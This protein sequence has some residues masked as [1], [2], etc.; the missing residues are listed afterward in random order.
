[1]KADEYRY[2]Q[3]H[4]RTNRTSIWQTTTAFLGKYQH[5]KK[6]NKRRRKVGRDEKLRKE[7]KEDDGVQDA[8]A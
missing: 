1:M 8:G 6:N 3:S 4:L 7:H 5:E 2:R